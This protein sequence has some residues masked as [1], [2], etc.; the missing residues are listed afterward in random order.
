MGGFGSIVRGALAGLNE[1]A[2]NSQTAQA[3]QQRNELERQKKQ[4]ELQMRVMPHAIAIQGINQRLQSLDP[5]DPNYSELQHGLQQ[6]I[7]RNLY[8]VRQILHPDKDES[9]KGNFFERGI[10]DKL[11]LSSVKHRQDQAKQTNAKGAAQDQESAKG[12]A[13]GQTPFTETPTYQTAQMK[14]LEAQRAEQQKSDAALALQDKKEKEALALEDKKAAS[15]QTIE[16]KRVAAADAREREQQAR[17]EASQKAI[18]SRFERSQSRLSANEGTWSVAEDADGKPILFNSKTGQKKDAP[19]GLHKS[20]YFAKQIAPLEAAS[21][22]IKN[23]VDGGVF[24]G[25]GDLALQHEFFT[26][27]QPSTGFRMTKV[28]QDILQESQSWLNSW[29]AKVHHATTGT[30]FSDEQRKQIARA[31]QE[32]IDAKKKVLG[33]GGPKTDSLDDTRGQQTDPL[34][35]LK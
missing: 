26:A 9:G 32:A 6:D 16:D 1:A 19:E 25:A 31:A 10:T 18:E 30:W 29:Q 22:N 11:H 14:A 2:G 21:L 34:G 3:L 20:G 17:F 5:K 28:Q 33:S 7:A 13:E 23:Y 4:S 35:I 12:I 8:E 15:A 27:T 24:D